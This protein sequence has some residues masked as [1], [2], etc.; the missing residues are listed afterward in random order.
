[1]PFLP[2]F[3]DEFYQSVLIISGALTRHQLAETRPEVLL[4]PQMSD[5]LW[6]LGF[7]RA[8]EAIRA[9]ENAAREMLDVIRS[10]AIRP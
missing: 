2:D 9:G 10:L 6:L 7:D 1:V 8:A 3:G 5:E 4:Q